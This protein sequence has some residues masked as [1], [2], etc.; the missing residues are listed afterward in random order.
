M[1]HRLLF[2]P[3]AEHMRQGAKPWTFVATGTPF[4]EELP[5]RTDAVWVE[6]CLNAWLPALAES[7]LA[8]PDR[9]LR[10]G[11]GNGP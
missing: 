11:R 9:R 3:D 4:R 7:G 6:A 8:V 5:I 2:K 1:S 10:A